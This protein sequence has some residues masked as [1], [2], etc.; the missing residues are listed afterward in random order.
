MLR[1]AS[2]T[3]IK[4]VPALRKLSSIGSSF[5]QQTPVQPA[6][7]AYYSEADAMKAIENL[8]GN[9]SL[10]RNAPL[11]LE[12]VGRGEEEKISEDWNYASVPFHYFYCVHS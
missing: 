7:I 8:D 12:Y 6:L 2:I 9:D 11:V 5:G 4:F 1:V 3:Q 10:S